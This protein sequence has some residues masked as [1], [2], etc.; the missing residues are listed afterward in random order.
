[1]CVD[2]YIIKNDSVLE[3][4]KTGFPSENTDNVSSLVL[5]VKAH[6]K[7]SSKNHL[8]SYHRN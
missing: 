2:F 4:L 7:N 3:K 6:Y 5:N 1:M 8:K